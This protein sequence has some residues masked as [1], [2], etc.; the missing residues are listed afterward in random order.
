MGE[1][2]VDFGTVLG[3]T[4]G[5]LLPRDLLDQ[6]QMAAVNWRH[7]QSGI[8]IPPRAAAELESLWADWLERR[9]SEGQKIRVYFDSLIPG[10]EYDRLELAAIWGYK[11]WHAI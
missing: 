2:E 5:S 3:P 4:A 6:G 1:G 11:E 9:A 7:Q 8:V 10:E